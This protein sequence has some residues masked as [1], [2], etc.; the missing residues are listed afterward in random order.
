ML[1]TRIG[2]ARTS[3]EDGIVLEKRSAVAFV[4][5]F[6]PRHVTDKEIWGQQRSEE[7][8]GIGAV[9]EAQHLQDLLQ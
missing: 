3:G 7:R 1:I 4:P 9:N 2:F 6:P 8:S 5:G